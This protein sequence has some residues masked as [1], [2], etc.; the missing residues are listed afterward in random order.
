[1]NERDSNPSSDDTGDT[2][3]KPHKATKISNETTHSYFIPVVMLIVLCVIIVSTF[4]SKEFNNLI[5]G[6]K[7]PD[8]ADELASDV[9]EQT[10]TSSKTIDKPEDDA[11]SN[12]NTETASVTGAPR[13]ATTAVIETTAPEST[14]TTAD[15]APSDTTAT[16]ALT[17]EIN[18]LVSMKDEVSSPYRKNHA[19]YPYE[20]PTSHG[21]TQHHQRAYNEMRG[22]RRR[23]HEEA[24]QAHREHMIKMHEYRAAVLKRI[25]Q[26]RLDMYKRIREIDQAHQRRLDEQMNW[27]ELEEKR[28]MKR[29]I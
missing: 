1:M 27:M 20:P 21:M 19:P 7:S 17:S 2:S 6:A 10:Q 3:T 25:E 4:Y 22:Q 13:E 16:Q 24:M 11:K 5:A 9:T 15:T 23:S 26:D 14:F 28:S 8:Q 12:M 29:P 18:S